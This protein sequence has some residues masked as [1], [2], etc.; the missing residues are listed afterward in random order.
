MQVEIK[1]TYE[2]AELLMSLVRGEL[3]YLNQGMACGLDHLA[4]EE[5]RMR[6]LQRRIGVAMMATEIV[7]GV[8]HGPVA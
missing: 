6:N 4:G 3:D 1:V 7:E 5:Q 2:E 8:V